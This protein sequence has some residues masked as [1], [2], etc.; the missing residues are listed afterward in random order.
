MVKIERN[1]LR[2]TFYGAITGLLA[3]GVVLMFRWYIET[4]QTAFLPAGEAGNYEALPPLFRLLL[5]TVGGVLLG[6]VFQWIPADKRQVG[7]VYVL[8]NLRSSAGGLLSIRNA[9]VQFL[10]GGAAIILGHSVDREG[11]GVHLGAT[12]GSYAGAHLRLSRRD[13]R[14]LVACGAAASIAAAFNTP[15]A[16]AVFVIE[17]LRYRYHIARFM[18]IIMSAVMG[19]VVIRTVHGSYP[20]FSVPML[21]MASLLELPL[22][23]ILGLIIGLL[24]G[25]F[26][27]ASEHTAKRCP[28]WPPAIAFGAAGLCTGVLALWTPQIMGIGYDTL[29][30]MLNNHVVL[31]TVAGIV[32]FKLIATA[33]AI[34]MRVPGGLIGPTLVI[35]GAMGSALG[36]IINGWAPGET[37]SPAFYAVIGMVAMMGAALQAPLAALIAL[38][39]LTGTPNI[40]LPGMLAVVSAD[41]VARMIMGRESVFMVLLRIGKS[42]QK[43]P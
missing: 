18:P 12:C 34:G 16:G 3:G 29:D 28:A 42:A 26:I 38:L 5:P 8:N 22:V 41:I 20:S 31:S 30:A 19:A 4:T 15:L 17:V 11:P 32:V 37:G 9:I 43:E 24:A 25:L 36:I 14:T 23:G 21:D 1:L 33:V 39:E 2:L 7:I 10:G 13:Q 27:T 40:I 35:G 6:L